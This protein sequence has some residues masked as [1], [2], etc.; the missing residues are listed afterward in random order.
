[1]A[2]A[3]EMLDIS[4]AFPGV[5]ANDQ[6]TF[7]VETG[8]I[9]ALV[10]ENG[11]GKSTLMNILYGLLKPDQGTIRVKGREITIESSDDAIL[12][13]IGMVHQ[14]F[15]LIPSFTIMENICLGSEPVKNRFMIDKKLELDSV[16]ALSRRYRL[17]I[18]PKIR[19][20]DCP[21]GIQQRVEILKALYRKADI[22]ILDEPT[23]VLTPQETSELFKVIRTLVNQGKT[24]I[25]ITH[26]LREVME[27]SD[28]VTVMR[29]GKL[30]GSMPTAET[31]P[32]EIA[33]MMVGREVLL[34]VDKKPAKPSEDAVLEVKDLV[35]ADNRGLL[36]VDQVFFEVR[37]G[38]ILG[39]AGV[40]GNGQ[41][42]LVEA[43]TGLKAVE[44][45]SI[46]LNAQEITAVLPVERRKA[47][48]SHI[49][50]DRIRRGLNLSA[51]IEENL[52]VTS[53]NQQPFARYGIFNFPERAKHADKLIEEFDI[54][55]TSRHNSV[56][57]LSGG[58]MQKIV[59]A[60]EIDENPDL[61]IAAQP[62]RGVDIGSIEFI[63]QRIINVRDQG[64]AVLLVSTELDEII[65]LSDR[66]AVMYEG[67]IVDIVPAGLATE[68]ELG[69]LMA[70]IIP[71]SLT[72][73]R[74]GEG[75]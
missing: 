8:E 66:I 14:K 40:Q 35:V 6:V 31:N 16:L 70:G 30:V 3:V 39:I 69:L 36:A 52:I 27:I 56:A 73:K 12:L 67:K 59:V 43:L 26:K 11:A 13:G 47:G 24:V 38:E 15:K 44:K 48:L 17:D 20:Q 54:R 33:R 32:Q 37:S 42:E 53:H 68:E 10:G 21:V 65:S 50:E 45:G 23:G 64:K 9:H 5:L 74:R 57:S 49:P 51:T 60:R 1:M 7:K 62:T 63:H 46:K 25:F 22:L 41:S 29:K 58:N 18:D 75:N 61:L 2:Y 19:I 4:K 28:S 71:E 55:T 72:A 34:R